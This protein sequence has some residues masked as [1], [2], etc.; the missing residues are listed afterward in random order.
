MLF[1]IYTRYLNEEPVYHGS[2][3]FDNEMEATIY[4]YERAKD[5]FSQHE[6]EAALDSFDNFHDAL[7]STVD[8]WVKEVK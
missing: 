7:F 3:E 2:E 4:A 8:F 5:I 1:K 6:Y